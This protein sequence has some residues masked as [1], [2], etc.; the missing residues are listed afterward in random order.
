VAYNL[1]T[2]TNDPLR[3]KITLDD[4]LKLTHAKGID[5]TFYPSEQ[6]DEYF[7]KLV[8]SDINPHSPSEEKYKEDLEKEFEKLNIVQDRIREYGPYR[9][10][11]CKNSRVIETV[12]DEKIF[13][14]ENRYDV[15][16]DK[17]TEVH[18]LKDGRLFGMIESG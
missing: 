3:V 14:K 17:I 15:L 1:T 2:Y 11:N 13:S 9:H 8:A 4:I 10:F 5:S 7:C 18:R 6:K 12:I 16:L